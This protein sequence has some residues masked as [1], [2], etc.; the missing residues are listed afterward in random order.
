MMPG[1]PRLR[2][3][4]RVFVIALFACASFNA[5]CSAQTEPRFSDSS[6]VAPNRP[7]NAELT[8]EGP[9]VAPPDHERTWEKVL[10]TPF[11]VAFFPARLIARGMEGAAPL[12]ELLMPPSKFSFGW[13]GF[14]IAPAFG[15]SGAAGPALGA[16]IKGPLALGPGSDLRLSGTW[17]FRDHRKVRLQAIVGEDV[18]AVG[19]EVTGSH[20][21]RP[22]RRF[23]GIGNDAL[24]DDRTIYFERENRAEAAVFAGRDPLRRARAFVAYSAFDVGRGYF[25]SPKAVDVF[26][27]ADVP[28]LRRGSEVI[29]YGLSGDLAALDQA[30]D[31]SLGVHFRGDLARIQ[32]IDKSDL[33]YG[34]WRAESRGYLPVFASRRVLALRL[35]Y[36]GVDPK[37][38]S[39]GVPFYRLPRSA[40][41]NRFSAYASGQFRDR[42]LILGHAEYR[43]VIVEHVWAV[44][45]AQLGE[46]ASTTSHFRVR[47]AHPSYGGGFRVALGGTRAARLEIAKG[48][49]NVQIYLDL[50]GDF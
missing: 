5:A 22:N 16:A 15:M 23:Y 31:P 41:E 39:E 34:A 30:R 32:S 33:D 26:D 40:G 10:R 12:T 21:Y 45:I 50:K 28:F 19:F 42:H 3:I 6:W 11:R 24:R 8:S 35:A 29:V 25:G 49:E 46:V 18:S 38:G 1:A 2:L 27:P 43:W 44:A 4:A 13:R 47:D 14:R 9:R 36:E 20:D 48:D 17:S 37:S 7:T